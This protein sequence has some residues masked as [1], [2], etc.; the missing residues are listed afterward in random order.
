MLSVP[1]KTATHAMKAGNH[2]THVVNE[3]TPSLP[4]PILPMIVD[5]SSQNGTISS[6]PSDSQHS[7]G[8]TSVP[9][10]L[11]KNNKELNKQGME[12]S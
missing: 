7:P 12:Q 3:M 2:P 10:I 8:I 11:P 4:A 6:L 1:E 5:K 9:T